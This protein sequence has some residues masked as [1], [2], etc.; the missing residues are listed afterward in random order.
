MIKAVYN[1]PMLVSSHT[2]SIWSSWNHVPAHIQEVFL[3]TERVGTEM[4][5]FVPTVVANGVNIDVFLKAL[6]VG[7]GVKLPTGTVYVSK[8]R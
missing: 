3:T 8:V 7:E 2:I 5:V 6:N 1:G 4:Y